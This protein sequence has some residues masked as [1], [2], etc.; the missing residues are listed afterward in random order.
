MSGGCVHLLYNSS[1]KFQ[2]LAARQLLAGTTVTVRKRQAVRPVHY[3]QNYASRVTPPSQAGRRVGT[4]LFAF[5]LIAWDNV[6]SALSL[7]SMCRNNYLCPP[8]SL[9]QCHSPL[10]LAKSF[11]LRFGG[12]MPHFLF[13]WYF[14]AHTFSQSHSYLTFICRH[15]P[16]FLSISS[17]IGWILTDPSVQYSWKLTKVQP[18]G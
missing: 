12:M 4:A 15:S 17:A 8:F 2:H 6:L 18:G 11:F 16:K 7:A 14:L 3:V 10:S 5:G 1:W 9:P 13:I